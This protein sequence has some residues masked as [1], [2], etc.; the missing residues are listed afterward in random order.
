[1]PVAEP[2]AETN[3][4]DLHVS[5]LQVALAAAALSNHGAIPAPRLAT[6]VNTPTNGW[7]VLAA[8]GKSSTA[9]PA[10]AADDTAKSLMADQENFW[11]H[12]GQAKS[13][14]A[15][16]TW[17]LAGTPPTWQASPMVVVVLLEE[18]NARLAQQIGQALLA[19]VMHA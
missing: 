8:L 4:K 10:K 18:E 14:E 17:F 5:P 9:I 13:Q 3:T 19:D 16:V 6:A 2:P 1:M 7:V 11:S 15:P 12:V